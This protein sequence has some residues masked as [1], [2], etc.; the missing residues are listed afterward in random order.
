MK[1]LRRKARAFKS[2]FQAGLIA[3]RCNNCIVD[4]VNEEIIPC[5][6]HAGEI[7]RLAKINEANN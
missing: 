5:M 7:A 6:L 3:N 2:A 1:S 4:D